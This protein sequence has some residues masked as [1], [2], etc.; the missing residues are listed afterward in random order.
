MTWDWASNGGEF[1]KTE[2]F[3]MRREADFT[4]DSSFTLHFPTTT[5]SLVNGDFKYRAPS[6]YPWNEFFVFTGL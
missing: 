1:T 3:K 5:E 2:Y 4:F 6:V